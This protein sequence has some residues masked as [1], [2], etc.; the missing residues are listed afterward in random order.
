MTQVSQRV[1]GADGARARGVQRI[2]AERELVA[3]DVEPSRLVS[4]HNVAWTIQLMDAVRAAI[5]AG[6]IEALRRQI[7]AVWA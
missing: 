5:Q 1:A 6:T 4:V 7:L 2:V 3:L